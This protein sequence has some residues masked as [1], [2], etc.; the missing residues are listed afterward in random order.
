MSDWTDSLSILA[1]AIL[2]ITFARLAL[3]EREETRS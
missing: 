2:A 3:S 1:F